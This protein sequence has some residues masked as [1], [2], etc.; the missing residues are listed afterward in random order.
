MDEKRSEGIRAVDEASGKKKNSLE[1]Q[2][3]LK[4]V[5]RNESPRNDSLNSYD[6]EIIMMNCI[7]PGRTRHIDASKEKG[8]NI[9]VQKLMLKIGQMEIEIL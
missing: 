8:K 2:S 3:I 6:I 7:E 1:D 5:L 9:R 4:T